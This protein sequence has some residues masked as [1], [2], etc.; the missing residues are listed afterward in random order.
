[1]LKVGNHV[2]KLLVQ[3]PVASCL[4]GQLRAFASEPATAHEKTPPELPPFNYQPQPYIGPS[5]EEV[6]S[7]RKKFLSPCKQQ[8]GVSKGWAVLRAVWC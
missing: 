8:H 3:A 5:K 4:L 2:S 7:L 6:L 1:M